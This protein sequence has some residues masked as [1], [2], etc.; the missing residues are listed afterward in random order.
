MSLEKQKLLMSTPA[1][2]LDFTRG[3]R[4]NSRKTMKLPP[5]GEMRHDSP[6]L[7]PEQCLVPK[8]TGKEP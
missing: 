3:S 4:R 7:H 8:Q 2:T 5:R 6:A 1:V